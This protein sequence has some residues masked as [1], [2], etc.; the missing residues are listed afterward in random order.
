MTDK[1]RVVLAYSGGL[2]TSY[3]IPY[4]RETFDYDVVTVTVDTGG[5]SADEL[6]EIEARAV[7]LGA[8]EHRT[9]D[10]RQAVFDQYV[11]YLIKGNVLRGQVYPLAVAAERVVQ[12]E[13]IA[14]AARAARAA[15]IAHGST[16]AGND[17]VRFDVA[18]HVL[19]P[20]LEVLTPIR[21]QKLSRDEEYEYLK[22]RGVDIDPSV[23]EY[24]INAGLWGSTIGGGVTHDPWEEIP[25][26]V[27]DQAVDAEPAKDR[28]DVTIQFEG[29]LPVALD[30]EA[31]AG[32]DLVRRL[33]ELCRSYRAGLGIHIG[34]TVLGIK[35][36]IAF[37][38]GAAVVLIHAHREL[39]KITMTGWQRF[40]K[41]H[42]A[43]FY[44][45]MLHEGLAFEPAL[46]DIEAL[47]DRSQERV[48][49]EAR[50]RLDPGRF[51]RDGCE[52]S[53]QPR[54]RGRRSVRGDADALDGRRRQGLQPHGGDSF[55]AAS[56][57]R[58]RGRVA[59]R[60]V[61]CPSA[62]AP[63]RSTSGSTRSDPSCTDSDS[64]RTSRSRRSSSPRRGTRSSF[65]R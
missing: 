49:G 39:E 41:D 62:P 16:G 52:E 28:R 53:A 42:V 4:L 56:I 64:K 65:E 8:V 43:E 32:R 55:A 27:F 19:C 57:G 54:R 20:E 14:E 45:K 35:G 11:S 47:I 23:R 10:A 58:R 1:K 51:R 38:A 36:R 30:G 13:V 2:D 46:R 22:A 37:E 31:L 26:S 40:W 7:T 3:C 33:G 48:S 12:A 44:G 61:T 21:D 63:P 5:F 15:A 18:F 29:G 34:D 6:R 25:D 17:Q 60:F 50:V 24:S 59:V 9:I